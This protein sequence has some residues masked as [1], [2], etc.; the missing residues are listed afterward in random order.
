[1]EANWPLIIPPLLALLDD[2]S[3]V[4]KVRGCSILDRFLQSVP[5]GLLERTGLGQVFQGTL[6]PYLLYLPSLT[7]EDESRQ[8]LDAVYPALLIL[9]RARYNGAREQ[10]PRQ[11]V[12]DSI[13]R[14]GVLKGYTTAGDNARIATILMQKMNDLIDEMALGSCTH[15]KVRHEIKKYEG[16]DKGLADQST[17][18]ST[19]A[20]FNSEPSVC[21]GLSTATDC[22]T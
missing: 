16:L 2:R 8:L 18:C 19:I 15:L 13:F 9:T 11:K 14:Y 6:M 5:N 4:Y 21:D 3:T 20:I 1:M 12:L 10:A 17:A 7:P 22:I